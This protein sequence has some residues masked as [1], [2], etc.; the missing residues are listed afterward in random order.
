MCKLFAAVSPRPWTS[1]R[2]GLATDIKSQCNK[3]ESAFPNET[4][5]D[6]G[7]LSLQYQAILQGYFNVPDRLPPNCFIQPES[8]EQVSKIVTILSESQCKFAVKGGGHGLFVGCNAIAGGVTIDLQ[9]MQTTTLSDDNTTASV[10]PGAKWG[11]VYAALDPQGYAIP[12]GRASDVGV[13]GLTLGGGNSFYA[14]RYGLVCDNVKNYEIVLGNGT[15]T[16]ANAQQNADLYKALKG[17]SGNLGLVT[18]FDYVA[19][20]SGPLWGGFAFYNFTEMNKF[21]QPFVDFGNNIASDPYGS[22][23]ILWEN[24]A[25]AGTTLVGNIYDFT[26]DATNETYFAET[27]VPTASNPLPAP[28]ADFAFDK[29]GKPITN[30]FRVDS[31]YGFVAELNTPNNTRNIYSATIFKNDAKVLASVDSIIQDA[32][33]DYIEGKQKAPYVI[34]QAQYQPIPRIITNHS[35]QRGGNVLGLDRVLDNSILLN[36]LFIWDDPSKDQE[37]QELLSAILSKIATYTKSVPGGFRDWQYLNYA[38]ADQDP[39]GSYGE[40]NIEYLKSI[41]E[42]YDPDQ[43]FQKLVPGGWK[44]GDAGKRNKHFKFNQFVSGGSN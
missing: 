43:V 40:D 12:G 30:T 25:T 22:L 2:L 35:I 27:D 20:K 3:L 13:A 23:I 18:R 11:D 8:A 17:G 16:N 26:G 42:K 9:S 1:S 5:T 15:L 4:Y 6:T 39:I 41:S 32:L 37:I 24:N 10:Q 38:Y 21:Y 14:A 28:F 44:L 29:V 36:F 31:L 19:F 7:S 34:A 33:R